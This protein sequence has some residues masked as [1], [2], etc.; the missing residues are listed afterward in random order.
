[1][2][3]GRGIECYG[4]VSVMGGWGWTRDRECYARVS[5]QRG[6]IVDGVGQ[7]VGFLT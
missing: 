5:F 4:R 6:L 3:G 2:G 7:L 1:M